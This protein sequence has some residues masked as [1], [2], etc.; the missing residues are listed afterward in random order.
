MNL[1]LKTFELLQNTGLNWTVE[2]EPL[3]TADGRPTE[4]FG[5]FRS[6]NRKWLSSVGPQYQVMQNHT[7]A[8]TVIKAAA[9]INLDV[10]RGGSF[11]EGRKVYLQA[12]LPDKYIGN[13]WVKRNITALNSHD[14]SSAIAFGTTSTVVICQN[15]FYKALRSG[16]LQRFR[17]TASAQDR[18]NVALV[19][20]QAA[21]K[22]ESAVM[23]NFDRMAAID[24]RDEMAEGLITR[25]LK[26]G[27]KVDTD[28]ADDLSARKR[29]QVIA[30]DGA[31]TREL[32][33]EGRTLWGLF[34][35]VTRYTNHIAAPADRKL[36]YVMAGS[37]HALNGVAYEEIMN[38]IDA[39]VDN[40]TLV[41]VK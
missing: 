31:I 27:M 7:L 16:E 6:D 8:E 21:L 13:S 34:N 33:D 3:L 32:K 15:T 40:R 19:R 23:T 10:D 2:R 28:N 1:Y 37:G 26:R 18:L 25:I 30:L 38:W 36:D 11:D 14:G 17:H 29:N 41:P 39:N 5:L 12:A 9:T 24:L 22:E 20:V 4:T 35:G